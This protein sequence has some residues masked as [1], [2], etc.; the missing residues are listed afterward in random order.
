MQ[1]KALHRGVQEK[2]FISDIIRNVNPNDAKVE[3]A[4]ASPERDFASLNKAP[5]VKL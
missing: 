5:R 4:A 1:V 3:S 2:K